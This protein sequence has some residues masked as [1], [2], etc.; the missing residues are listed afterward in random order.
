MDFGTITTKVQK[1]KYRS[2]EEF[3]NDIRL[4]TANAKTFNPLG[5][6]YHSEAERIEA[7]AIDHINKAAASVIEYEADW[8]IDVERDE[9]P[10]QTPVIDDEDRG[11]PMDI[12]GSMGGRSPS[13]ASQVPAPRRGAKSKK[14]AGVLSESLEPD[15]HLP[16]FKDGVGQFS[17]GSEWA[18]LMLSLKLKGKRYRT[19]KERLRVEKSG[20]PLSADGSIDYTQME[21]P[22]S[23]LSV[24]LPEPPSKP[25]LTSLYPSSDPYFPSP[26]TLP[27]NRPQPQPPLHT[28]DKSGT[29][30]RRRYWSIVRSAPARRGKDREGEGEEELPSWKAPREPHS[31]DYGTFA[32]LAGTLAQEYRVQNVGTDLG[33]EA[34]LFGALR[35]SIDQGL[36]W[37][38]PS[39]ANDDLDLTEQGY[40]AR[41]GRAAED[42]IRDVVYGGVDGLAYV[43]SLADFVRLPLQTEPSSEVPTYEA[44]GMP[45]ARYVE[46][47]VIDPLTD[48]RHRLVREASR[49][50][51]EPSTLSDTAMAAEV[52]RA[53]HTLP[54]VAKVLIQLRKIYTHPLDMAALIKEANELFKADDEWAGKAYMEE[55]R[56][57][58]EKEQ[59]RVEVE[60]ER[61]LGEGVTGSNAMQYLAF[62]IKSH[63]QAQAADA[64]PAETA[65]TLEYALN[66]SA[67][68]ITQLA[69]RDKSD[70]VVKVE[71]EEDGGGEDPLLRKL[72]LNLL[73]LAKRAPL[74]KISRLPS[75]LVPEAIRHIVPTI[76][77]AA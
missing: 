36:S 8:N 54:Q 2:L 35:H 11:T 40:W 5:T 23:V 13:V 45:L 28:V 47:T 10:S 3:A 24:F 76:E 71:S 50:L 4:V 9:E 43:R 58:R 55:K 53:L 6:I 73:S 21:D 34:Q 56:E 72:R 52:H 30:S 46:E 63:E 14:E 26:S 59:K 27:R 33:S 77:P 29:K 31:T 1:G 42:Y 60:H 62:A 57:E 25:L 7:Y 61:A 44:L 70:G 22:F 19:K 49:L 48:G 20:P 38:D 75:D 69:K 39:W 18:N 37:R 12:D 17:P 16:G 32:T 64:P 74:D 68:L 66:F 41:R 65:E 51:H 15:G 67:D